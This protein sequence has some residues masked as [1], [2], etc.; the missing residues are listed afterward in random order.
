MV[1]TVLSSKVRLD[2]KEVEGYCDGM[3]DSSFYTLWGLRPLNL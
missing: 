1:W 3:G 2:V